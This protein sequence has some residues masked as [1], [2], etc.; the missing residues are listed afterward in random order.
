MAN[1]QFN[2]ACLV[3]LMISLLAAACTISPYGA[4]Q[5]TVDVGGANAVMTLTAALAQQAV[6][7]AA[8]A[9]AAP[10]TT[11]QA[12]ATQAQQTADA[13]RA[14]YVAI[15]PTI[16]AQQTFSA[17][18][19]VAEQTASALVAEAHAAEVHATNTAIA[20]ALLDAER[21][22][23]ATWEVATATAIGEKTQS[24][25]YRMLEDAKRL[26]E[27]V[28]PVAL[29]TIAVVAAALAVVIGGKALW[30]LATRPWVLRRES[31]EPLPT[32]VTEHNAHLLIH[33]ADRQLYPTVCTDAP[34]HSAVDAQ[35][36]VTSQAQMAELARSMPPA[37][38]QAVKRMWEQM[39]PKT[40]GALPEQVVR[41]VEVEPNQV[42]GWVADVEGQLLL[43]AGMEEDL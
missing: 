27:T 35:V 21:N 32:I 10:T 13:Q 38:R 34:A 11:A 5:P 40:P 8:L 25:R 18:T 15:T 41:I 23:T 29:A 16:A 22:A 1:R 31:G 9:Q 28:A 24:D 17:A 3:F 7:N 36:Q 20:L 26:A 43:D 19:W 42:Q 33:Q 14:T 30:R 2:I 37:Q 4:A 12:V 6:L 39:A